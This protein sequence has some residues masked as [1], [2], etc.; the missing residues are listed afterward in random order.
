MKDKKVFVS[1]SDLWGDPEKFRPDRFLGPSGQLNKELT[2]KVLIFGVGK[3]RCVGDGFAR[4]EMFVFLTTL[5]QGLS[6]E[7]VPG[8]KLD[9][10]ADFGL[11]MKPRPYRIT[12]S[13]RF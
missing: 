10:G 9:L 4:L 5:L 6:I 13:S 8:Q 12:V 2:E 7:N 3:R 1:S 11:T